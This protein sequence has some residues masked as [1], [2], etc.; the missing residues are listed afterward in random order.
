[1]RV[2]VFKPLLEQEDIASCVE[3]LEKGWLGMGSYVGQFEEALKRELGAPEKFVV[4]VNT[5][6]SALHLG[7]LLAGVGPG[8]EVITPSFNNIADLQAIRATGAEP[9]FCDVLPDTLCIDPESAKSVVSPR[10][11]VII[12]MDYGASICDHER[13]NA[14]ASGC[15]ARVIHDAAHSFGSAVNG[16]KIGSFSDI[17]M[18]SFDPVKNITTID[19]GALVVNTQAEATWLQE[20]RLIGMGQPA[21][22]MY[23]DKRAW[24]YDVAHLG[25]RYHMANL[26]AALGLAQLKKL[27][28]I[29]STRRE[30]YRIYNKNFK[31][32]EALHLPADPGDEIVPFIYFVRVKAEQ[33]LAFRDHLH[34]AGVDTGIHWQ[35]G[36]WF[37]YFKD[38]RASD[39]SVTERIGREILTLPLHSEMDLDLVSAVVSAVNGFYRT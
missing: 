21:E 29:G 15:G 17:A 12:A 34:A 23:Q 14:V 9:V 2:P 33:R 7:L 26:H 11:K 18:F 38:C 27:P 39:L 20:A 10:T 22:V 30:T 24:T 31:A 25:F 16:R 3:S 32:I 28:R 37:S 1:M 6:H 35:P 8:D 36:H 4:A 13:I 5:G 19:G